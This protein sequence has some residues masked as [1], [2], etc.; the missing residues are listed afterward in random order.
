[1]SIFKN[2]IQNWIQIA[3]N[4]NSLTIENY[5]YDTGVLKG[6]TGTHCVKCVAV[7]Y[8]YFK[9]EKGKKPEK[10]DFNNINIMN[11]LFN[12]LIP[13]LYHPKCHCLEKSSTIDGFNDIKL[14]IPP[15]KI[16]YLFRNKLEW[17]NAMGYHDNDYENFV[18][19]LLRKTKEAYFYGNYYI[20]NISKYGCKININV[21]IPGYNEKKGR[22]YNIKTNYMVF[23]HKKLKMNTPMGGWQK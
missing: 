22:E 8:C 12:G 21:T 9:D 16:N 11:F 15:G 4:Q 18:Q 7:N 23:P 5:G 2:V 19:I 13:G 3:D 6:T 20:E 17:V 10:F 1:M 14:I